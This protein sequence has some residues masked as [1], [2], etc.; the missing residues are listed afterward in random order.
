VIK[1]AMRTYPVYLN[2]LSRRKVVVIGGG[3]VAF[4]KV[5]GLLEA[6]ASVTL[7]SPIIIHAFVEI[8]NNAPLGL[9]QREYQPG[10]LKGA[11]LVIAATNNPKV[12]QAVWEE[13]QQENCLINVADDPARCNFILPAQVKHGDFSIAISTGG[14]SPALSRWL[15]EK[16]E[17]D[18]GTEYGDLTALL[19]ELRPFLID[20]FPTSA[21][22]LDAVLRLLDSDLIECLKA[23]GMIKAKKY[24]MKL[25]GS[26]SNCG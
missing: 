5:Q 15:R 14:A 22:R 21:T 1:K 12:N 17:E 13:A 26:R 8:S 10:D 20:H 18:Y 25:L 4:R 16:L 9:V 24:A 11:F 2:N 7:I 23:E 19:G 6:G 3:N